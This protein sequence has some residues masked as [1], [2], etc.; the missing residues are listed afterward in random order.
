MDYLLK[1]Q[2]DQEALELDA[3]YAEAGKRCCELED[4]FA[5]E[6]L[7][8]RI[9]AVKSFQ[10]K[11]ALNKRCKNCF[12]LLNQDSRFCTKCGKRVEIEIPCAN[13]GLMLA[14]GIKFC[15][16]C[17]WRVEQ[18]EPAAKVGNT[19]KVCGKSLKEGAMFCG[20]CGA[21]QQQE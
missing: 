11:Q 2:M 15:P 5:D 17:G 18:A 19:C 14:E 4:A 1:R 20:G 3:L 9:D 10:E 21:K 13:C 8:K 16:K 7:Q 6:E 12:A